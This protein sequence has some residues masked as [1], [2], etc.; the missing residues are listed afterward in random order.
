MIIGSGFDR[1][2]DLIVNELIKAPF[3]FY[4]TGSRFFSPGSEP[5]NDDVDL[6]V[7]DTPDVI[8][9]LHSLGFI[10]INDRMKLRG[11]DVRLVIDDNG[12][13][14]ITELVDS[15]FTSGLLTYAE[16][17]GPILD[18]LFC[19]IRGKLIKFSNQK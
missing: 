15:L 5:K 9:F 12:E 3:K 19:M 8:M 7:L 11:I 14:L 17:R 6:F 2:V 10:R 16:V 1:G 4:L 18:K 13:R